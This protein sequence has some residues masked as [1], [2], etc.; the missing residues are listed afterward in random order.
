MSPPA[1]SSLFTIHDHSLTFRG[2]KALLMTKTELRLIAAPAMIGLS[3][4]PKNRYSTPAA[5]GILSPLGRKAQEMMQS[6]P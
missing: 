2:R 6:A 1:S 3:G 4:K 5:T